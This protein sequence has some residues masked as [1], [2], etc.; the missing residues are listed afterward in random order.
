MRRLIESGAIAGRNFV[1]S[2]CG[3]IGRRRACR[4][5]C[6]S[7]ACGGLAPVDLLRAVRRIVLETNVVALDVT[8]VS[9]PYDH[10]DITVNN[11]HRVI[12]ERLAG[13]SHKKRQQAE[14]E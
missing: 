8:E 14:R 3:A 10:A 13:L 1:Q 4:N 7:R 11:A 12:W 6:A 5:G 2:A 9:P